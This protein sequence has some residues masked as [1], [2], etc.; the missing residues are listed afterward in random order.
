MK[1]LLIFISILATSFGVAEI[2][3]AEI[4]I[5]QLIEQAR[6]TEGKVPVRELPRWNGARKILI[7]DIGLD[8]TALVESL[9]DVDF[10]IVPSV[11]QAMQYA[12]DVD[13]IIGFCDSELIAAASKL[14]WLQLYWAGAERCLSVEA[15]ADGTVLM[16]NMQKMSSPVIAEH[17]IAMLLSLA[18]NLPQFVHGMDKGLWSR[19]EAQTTGMTPIAGKKMLVAGLGGIG[20][21]VA[22]LGAALGMSVSGTRNSSRTGPDFIE[23]VG[24]SHELNVLAAEADVIVNALPLT[25]GTR[26]VFNTDF[27]AVAKH[28]AIFINVGRGKTVDTDA[29]L[30]ALESGSVSSAGL[31]VTDPE[32]LP[33]DSPLWQRED[34]II[35]PHVAGSGGERERHAVLLRENLRRY[36]SG[37]VLLNVVDPSKGY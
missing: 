31:D 25:D 2:S 20:M 19:M 7:W 18:R 35:T 9:P 6:I 3:R 27:F 34:V 32:P 4:S 37:D 12:S 14:V 28:G 5:D 24:L 17:A 26:A 33:S 30:V 21:E 8:V 11:A 29:L 13:A 16:S 10:I 15:V 22:R 36:M 1:K 23:Y